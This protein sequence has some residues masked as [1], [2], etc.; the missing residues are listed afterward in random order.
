[1]GT[2]NTV[3]FLLD[4]NI[5]PEFLHLASSVD[6]LFFSRTQVPILHIII[7][8]HY[9]ISFL[10][11]ITIHTVEFQLVLTGYQVLILFHPHDFSWFS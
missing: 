9:S 8:L 4:H 7:Y 10:F 5:K 6:F 11:F 1:M 3:F 2:L